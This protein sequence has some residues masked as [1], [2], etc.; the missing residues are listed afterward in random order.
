VRCIRVA[1][2]GRVQVGAVRVIFVRI[3]DVL[4]GDV[5]IG[6]VYALGN[7]AALAIAPVVA[8]PAAVWVAE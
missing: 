7:R 4:I 6:T 1:A 8:V 2:V 3:G 5:L